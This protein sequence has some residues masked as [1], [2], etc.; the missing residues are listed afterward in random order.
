MIR[1]IEARGT[2]SIFKMLFSESEDEEV[3]DVMKNTDISGP[4]KVEN[5]RYKYGKKTIVDKNWRPKSNNDGG[6][7]KENI[8]Q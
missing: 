4:K 6:S 3:R 1:K 2:G 5:I 8:V 7:D